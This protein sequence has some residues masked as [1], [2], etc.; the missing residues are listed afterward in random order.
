MKWLVR[1]CRE[2]AMFANILTAIGIVAIM[3]IGF[4]DR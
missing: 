1:K 3:L 4:Y 2:S